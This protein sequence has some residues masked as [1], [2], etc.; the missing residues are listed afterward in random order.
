MCVHSSLLLNRFKVS[1]DHFFYL[2]Y[3]KTL[4]TDV[5]KESFCPIIVKAPI[6]WEQRPN[7]KKITTA[8]C[9]LGKNL[10]LDIYLVKTKMKLRYLDIG[11]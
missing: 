8:S 2:T 6:R 3:S 10:A 7:A 9:T 1:D 11:R 4:D 5:D